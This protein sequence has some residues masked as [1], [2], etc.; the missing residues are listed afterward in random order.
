MATTKLWKVTDRLDHIIDY[1][2][3]IEK[4]SSL[5]DTV[6]YVSNEEK[7]LQRRYVTCINCDEN[8]P[9]QSMNNTKKMFNDEKEIVCFHGYQ[10]FLGNEVSA[11][12]AHQIGVEL[13]KQLWTDNFEVIITTHINTNNIHNHI[14]INATSFKD[15]HRFCN[16]KVDYRATRDASDDLCRKYKLSVI[17]QPYQNRK[18]NHHFIK[19]IKYLIANDI[20]LA[21]DQS[22]TLT[23]FFQIMR[24]EGYEIKQDGNDVQFRHP[25]A[26]KFISVSELEGEY[27][28]DDIENRIDNKPLIYPTE[29]KAYQRYYTVVEPY[30]REYKKGYLTPLARRFIR[31]QYE[32]GILP[33][34]YSRMRKYP[35]EVA[36]AVVR[37]EEI[38]HQVTMM[39]QN[40]INSIEELNKYKD[41]NQDKL[42][43]FI[44]KR[45]H[46]YNK[47]RSFKDE[48]EKKKQY[49]ALISEYNK[50]I[51]WYR[52]EV[53]MCDDLKERS[54]KSME[55]VEQKLTK[56]E[57][58]DRSR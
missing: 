37:L 41:D 23:S 26:R 18:S 27:S 4:T 21:I 47:I 1:V 19:R 44:R 54:L 56:N 17:E 51:K 31:W 49:R 50:E 30:Y 6:H 33:K 43:D 36:E 48:P 22:N 9:C 15:G 12:L 24:F 45:R 8:D 32:I 3:N 46:C 28:I 10:S 42:D 5:I 7:T 14:V 52:K 34:N 13:A 29:N 20:D 11:D 39:C 57:R 16:T 35:K 38:T 25:D 40:N 53:R 2:Y 55:R 58:K